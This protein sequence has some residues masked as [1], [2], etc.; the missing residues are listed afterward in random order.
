MSR[1]FFCDCRK[2]DCTFVYEREQIKY[3]EVTH[4]KPYIDIDGKEQ[5]DVINLNAGYVICP[6]CGADTII[7]A[8]RI[9]K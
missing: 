2:C 1:K 5:V 3:K 4:E 6:K 8:K 9:A 7:T